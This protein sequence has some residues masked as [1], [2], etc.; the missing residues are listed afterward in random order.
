MTGGLSSIECHICIIMKTM[1][2]IV[3]ILLAWCANQTALRQG[4]SWPSTWSMTQWSW[5]VLLIRP[6]ESI[7]MS[8]VQT[9]NTI[10]ASMNFYR[11]K[12]LIQLT[13]AVRE[14]QN[15]VSNPCGWEQAI[16][17]NRRL[18]NDKYSWVLFGNTQKYLAITKDSNIPQ[19]LQTLTCSW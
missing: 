8:T 19:F 15:F 16:V 18:W 11:Q 5:G 14:S 9:S 6:G 3:L 10:D 17:A 2:Y 7:I 12:L 13:W 1:K 4:L